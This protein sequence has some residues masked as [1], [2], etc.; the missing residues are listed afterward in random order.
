MCYEM[1]RRRRTPPRRASLLAPAH[2]LPEEANDRLDRS[3]KST[4]QGPLVS[5]RP[6]G[7]FLVLHFVSFLPSGEFLVL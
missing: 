6:L 3:A 2:Q 7:E 5:L 1:A 4:A